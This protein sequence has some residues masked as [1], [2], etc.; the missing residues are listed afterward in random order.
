MEMYPMV[1]KKKPNNKSRHAPIEE[2]YN[3][4]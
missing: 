4:K 2:M 3:T 1:W